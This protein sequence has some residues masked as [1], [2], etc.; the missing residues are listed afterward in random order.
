MAIAPDWRNEW[1]ASCCWSAQ[2]RERGAMFFDGWGDLVTESEVRAAV[3]EQG[4]ASL[5]EVEAVVLETDGSLTSLRRLEHGTPS[6]LANVSGPSRQ[7]HQTAH[8]N[9][10]NR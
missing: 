2:T 6:A 4:F 8:G 5:E 10:Q 9:F 3:R 7:A 1:I